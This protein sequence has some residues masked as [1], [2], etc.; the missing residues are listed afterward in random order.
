MIII[1]MVTWN[2]KD[3]LERTLAAI[4]RTCAG[5]DYRV[6]VTDNGSVDGSPEMLRQMEDEGKLKAYIMDENLG[7]E[8]GRNVHFAECIG[9][10]TIRMDDKVLP[11]AKGWLT[12][13]KAVADKHHA[14]VGP[15]YDESMRFLNTIAPPISYFG[16]QVDHG[17]G[18]P[19]LFIPA[20][21]TKQLGACDEIP[22]MVYGWGDCLFIERARLLGWNFGFSLHVPVEFLASASPERRAKAMEYHPLY[23]ERLREYKEAERDVF[24]DVRLTEGYKRGL[25]ARG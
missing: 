2:R 14:I 21:A 19:L 3:I 8:M 17:Q 20:E 12:A 6:I 13:L 18:G 9:H 25:E 7:T 16:W 10:D 4:E 23:L 11:L 1:S 15:P 22:G 24:I 5:E